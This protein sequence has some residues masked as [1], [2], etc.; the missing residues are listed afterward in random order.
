MLEIE[1]Y[2]VIVAG[3]KG[4]RMGSTTPKQFLTLAGKPLL[5]YSIAAFIQ[6]FPDVHIILVLPQQ[7]L[8]HA[9]EMLQ[10][11]THSADITVV[12]GGEARYHSVQMGLK[13]IRENSI[14]FIHDGARPLVSVELITRCYHQAVE[15]G[16]AV[17]AIPVADSMRLING[18][19]STPVDR[20]QLRIIQ[21]PQTFRSELILP[22]FQQPYD[23][24]FTDE[25]TVAEAY[26]ANVQL[27]EGER[28]NI[29][30][31]TPEDML[32][33]AVMVQRKTVSG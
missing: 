21:T 7:H 25:A 10:L 16:S 12:A 26:G 9:H 11:F 24:S 33:A 31:T 3:G 4:E 18:E 17:P 28:R 20:R 8:Y 2:A 30:V 23:D 14:V 1:K 19:T 6:A 15:Q 5:Y 22:A 32:I 27:I 29:K 13:E